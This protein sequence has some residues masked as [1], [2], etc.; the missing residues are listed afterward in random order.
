[1]RPLRAHQGLHRAAPPGSRR[2][3]DP[4]ATAALSY[5]L[6]PRTG[7]SP[8]PTSRSPSTRRQPRRSKSHHRRRL[9]PGQLEHPGQGHPERRPPLRRADARRAPTAD[10]RH[11]AQGPVV[12]P[13]RRR[14]GSDP[15]GPLEDLRQLRPVLRA[16]PARHG[17]PRLTVAP[18][19]CCALRTTRLQP[20]RRTARLLRRR[21]TRPRQRRR[22]PKPVLARHRRAGP[23]PRSTPTSS[24]RPTTSSCRRRVRDHPQRPAAASLH[25][26]EPRPDDRGHVQQRRGQHLLHRQPRRGHRRHLPQGQAHLRRGDGAAS[27][28]TFADLW[29]AQVSYT[30]SRLT[31]QLRRP[32]PPRDRPA[33][34]EHQLQLRPEDRC[35]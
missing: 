25:P 3:T 35:S 10:H 26:P 8:T 30:W 29:L 32:L 1:M 28:K 31:R 20:A 17:R 23:G 13:H 5:E 2:A 19:S 14:L 21:T 6:P 15:A 9:R 18:R 4:A 11:R 24:P 12:A 7:T 33:R 16:D 22:P 34:S 27:T